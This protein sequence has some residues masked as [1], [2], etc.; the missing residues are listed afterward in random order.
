MM[1]TLQRCCQAAIVICLVGGC[2]AAGGE[3]GTGVRDAT[4]AGAAS[5]AVTETAVDS[6]WSARNCALPDAPTAPIGKTLDVVK[7][8]FGAPIA[9]SSF[10]LGTG[11]IPPRMTLL[12]RLPLE[13]NERVRVREL[14][15]QKNGCQLV[16][17]FTA[18][19]GGW[20]AVQTARSSALGE[21]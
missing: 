16:V 3:A 11:L 20:R 2:G 13:G 18:K 9:D 7:A 14:I 15:W 12:N 6:S 10:T 21:H 1:S 4:P 5:S 19:S 17:W 8:S